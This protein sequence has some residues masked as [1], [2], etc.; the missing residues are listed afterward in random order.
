[1]SQQAAVAAAPTELR[2]YVE[3]DA[4]ASALLESIDWTRLPRHIAIIM[5]GNG[6][7]AARRDLPRDE[8]HRAGIQ[9]VR[10]VVET[11]ARAKLEALTL[12]AFSMEN[13]GRP[14]D[15]VETLMSLCQEYLR[16][17]LPNI[18]EQGI[19]FDTI[20]RMED[21]PETVRRELRAGAMVTAANRG[22]RFTIA[23][24]YGGRAEL[25]DA[26]RA[27]LV[28]LQAGRL[29]ID[30]IDEDALASY[31][32]TADLPD[33]DLLIRTSGELRVSNFLLYQI[34]YAEI[35]VTPGLWPDFRRGDLLQAIADFQRRQRRFGG[36]G[37]VRF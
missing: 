33:P 13:W 21:L 16:K 2:E 37:E 31:L 12:F 32:Y 7:W 6:R 11:A 17:E 22:L 35:W 5:D 19:R 10:E 14:D 9:A 24:S 30:D 4:R 36:V 28:D 1:M 26:V 29:N 27:A 3:S 25:V 20:G 18:Q 8:G 15:E 34:A 23:I